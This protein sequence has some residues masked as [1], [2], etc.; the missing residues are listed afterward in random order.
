[1]DEQRVRAEYLRWFKRHV[2][3]LAVPLLSVAWGQ[4]AI[5]SLPEWPAPPA[6][7]RSML[8]ALAAGAVVFGRA[9]K[10]RAVEGGEGD[11]AAV[12]SARRLSRDLAWAAVA[13]SIVGAALVPM[14][15]SS[16]DLYLTLG[17]ALLGCATMFPR[18]ADW[19][20]WLARDGA[21]GGPA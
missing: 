3:V 20:R 8:L 5:A 2:V 19:Q 1:V 12:A 21:T 18:E 7:L 15:R 17:F 14:T 4:T 9:L 11:E 13:P 10:T 6:G 16:L